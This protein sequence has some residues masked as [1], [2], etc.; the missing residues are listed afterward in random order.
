MPCRLKG[1][2]AVSTANIPVLF[3][4]AKDEAQSLLEGFAA[5]A[6]DY[7]AKPFQSEEVLARVG[8]HVSLSRLA[9]RALRDEERRGGG[10]DPAV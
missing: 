5:G 1:D 7:I 9:S 6:V 2:A 3:I 10:A 4:S 8:T